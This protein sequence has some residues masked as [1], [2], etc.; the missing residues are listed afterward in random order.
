[1]A[2]TIDNDP[3]VPA[4][5][6]DHE[7]VR[8]R[9]LVFAITLLAL[10]LIVPL[11]YYL[12]DDSHDERF[13]WRMFSAERM[14]V[15]STR[16]IEIVT[17]GDAKHARRIPLEESLHQAWLANIKRNRRPVVRRFLER[18]CQEPGVSGVRLVNRC[19]AANRTPLAPR[20]YAIDC[21]SGAISERADL[22][23]VDTPG[24]NATTGANSDAPGAAATDAAGAR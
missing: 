20:D 5:P 9:I 24:T 14:H 8:R 6:T 1:M 22:G 11:S 10:Q 3:T 2:D 21:A 17:A 7:R 19:V 12:R 16:A 13:A 18:R 4:R 23:P 15:C